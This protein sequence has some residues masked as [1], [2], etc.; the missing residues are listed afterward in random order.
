MLAGQGEA[1]SALALLPPWSPSRPSRAVPINVEP[2]HSGCSCSA[3]AASP[4]VPS[5]TDRHPCP[6]H[7]A[8]ARAQAAST[9]TSFPLWPLLVDY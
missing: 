5:P 8:S 6:W 1:V 3:A 7:P 2:E 4:H 9:A